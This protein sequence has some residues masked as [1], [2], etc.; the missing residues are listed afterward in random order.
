MYFP[1]SVEKKF[2][3]STFWNE[4]TLQ[5]LVVI[6]CMLVFIGFN[7]SRALVSIGMM[8][9]LGVS[10][11]FF[12]PTMFKRYFERKEMLVLSLFFMIVLVSGIY[13]SDKEDWL[14]WVRIKLPYL[15]LPLAFAPMAR[16]DD[17][18]FTLILYGYML[19]FFT[20]ASVVLINYFTHYQEMN[21]SFFKGGSIPMPY[22]HIRYTLMI[23]LSFFCAVYLVQGKKYVWTAA[24]KWP[25]IAYAVFVFIALHILAVRSA[26]IGLYLGIIFL[27]LRQV[28]IYRRLMAGAVLLLILIA[29]AFTVYQLVPSV[30]N[31]ASYMWYD[32]S[33][34]Q[35]GKINQYSDAMRLLS[36]E[37]GLE[38]WK[39]HKWIG[40]GAGSLKAETDKIYERDH[41]EIPVL[42]RRQPHN[43]FIW[44]MATT[45]IIGL[46]L[47]LTAFF[48]PVFAKGYYRHWLMVV[49]CLIV[50]SSLFTEVTLEEQ[51]GTGFYTIFLMLFMNHF[52]AE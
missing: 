46:L 18:K 16:L 37:V 10:L 19:A 4:N 41:P 30:R 47:F 38:I 21:E 27:A 9:L 8:G 17:K 24:E 50:F 35:E 22:S 45:G 25:Q 13:S 26:L 23:A 39:D 15:A 3:L 2:N 6:C 42:E 5:W 12:G 52:Q 49:F 1:V 28:I 48:Y 44:V 34:Y 11:L 36:M 43:Q 31:K 32:I 29:T 51:M 7:C 40:A 20:S 33:Q 14:N